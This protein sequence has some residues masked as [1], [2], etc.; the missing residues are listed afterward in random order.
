MCPRPV[1]LL[2]I[3]E[4]TK[5][6]A[7][8]KR[9]DGTR[10]CEAEVRTAGPP[11]AIRLTAE[12]DTVTTGLGDVSHVTFEI[13]DSAGV[14]VPT[15]ANMVRFAVTGGTMLA[16]DNADLHVHD[17]LPAGRKPVFNGRGLAILRGSRPGTMRLT[18]KA[19]LSLHPICSR[20]RW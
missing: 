14:V 13:V 7:V 18:A 6:K 2:R 16:L 11:A 19:E 9:R 12:R 8:G 3:G 5:G 10:A 15:A 17:S 4:V 20:A 1:R